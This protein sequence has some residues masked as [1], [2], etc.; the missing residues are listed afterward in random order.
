MMDYRFVKAFLSAARLASFSG[1]AKELRIAQSAVSRQIRLMETSLGCQLFFRNSKNVSLTRQGKA[2]FQKLDDVDQWVG[3]EFYD[4]PV[5]LRIAAIDGI[6]ESVVVPKMTGIRSAK[7][8]AI[9]LETLKHDLIQAAVE[10]G[11]V[12]FALTYLPVRHHGYVC[13]QL[14][15]QKMFLISAVPLKTSDLSG[16][17]W[18][19]MGRAEYLRKLSPKL[20]KQNIVVNSLSAIVRLVA[21]GAGIAVVPERCLIGVSGL[22]KKALS[23]S[24]KIYLIAR[25]FDIIPEDFKKLFR[26]FQA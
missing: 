1:A 16:E 23:E 18:I 22:Q 6:M 17:C 2:L 26:A 11:E 10:R 4:R 14:L 3:R 13:R 5:E 21:S 15:E 19:H 8:I 20:S 7:G 24:S 12:D 9:K 25:D